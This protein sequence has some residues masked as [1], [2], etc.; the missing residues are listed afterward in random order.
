MDTDDLSDEAYNGIIIEAEK[1]LHNLTIHFG[2]L[3]SSCNNEDE[4]IR[5]A[6]DLVHSFKHAKQNEYY[7]LFFGEVPTVNSLHKVLIQI[8][9][10]IQLINEIP[11]VKRNFSRWGMPKYVQ[12]LIQKN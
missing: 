1:F 3:A 8:E 9:N 5:S 12:N 2:V 7:D 11:L 4:Y 10:N 6:L